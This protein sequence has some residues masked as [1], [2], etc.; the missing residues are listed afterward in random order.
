MTL[1]SYRDCPEAEMRGC[2]GRAVG[3]V[4]MGSFEGSRWRLRWTRSAMGFESTLVGSCCI[5]GSCV[6]R[7]QCMKERSRI[8]YAEPPACGGLRRQCGSNRGYATGFARCGSRGQGRCPKEKGTS[9]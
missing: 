5:E 2:T 7:G 1:D 4:S 8:S 3:A 6:K 9:H